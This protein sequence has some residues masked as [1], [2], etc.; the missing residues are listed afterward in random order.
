MQD[1]WTNIQVPNGWDIVPLDKL[2]NVVRGGSPRPMGDPRYFGGTIP[3]V[4]ISDVTRSDGFH[5]YDVE[6]K[7]T[8]DGAKRSRL[9]K[10][11]RLILTNSATVCVPIFLGVD[12]CIHDG[13]VAFDDLPDSIDQKYLYHFFKYIRP[14]ILDKH[15]QGVTQVNLNTQIVGEINLVLAPT[16]EQHRIVAKIEELFSELDKG[17]ENLKT[18]RQ[19]LKVYREAVLNHAFV[20]DATT[21]W[22][23]DNKNKL[24]SAADLITRIKKERSAHHQA[25]ISARNGAPN[26]NGGKPRPLKIFSPLGRQELEELATL[27]DGW[28]WEKLG[29]MTCGVEYGTGAKSSQA[30]E[31]SVLRMGNIQNGKFDWSDLV[32]TSDKEEILKYALTEGDVLFNR[33]NSPEL[34]GKTAIYRGEHPALFA[35]YLIRVNQLPAIADSQYLNLFLNS[36]AAR[37]HGNRVK[38]DGV[39]QSNIN[40]EKLSNYPFPYCSLPEQIEIVKLL[41][42]KLSLVDQMEQEIGFEIRKA[43]SLRQSILKKAFAGRLVAQD[44]N[45]EPARLLLERI[46]AGKGSRENGKTKLRKRN[47]A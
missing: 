24:K 28:I 1:A 2:C 23:K 7:V 26:E 37:K 45:D 10:K 47:A 16:N 11:G 33:T 8:E 19:Q 38:T 40:G 15:K 42:E 39:N 5:L 13:F 35:G 30:G 20:G 36:H 32:Y 41:E 21:R 3:F 6:T 29:W 44:P 4:K 22:R 31:V 17:V 18:A 9:I 34:V 27:P 14:F 43:E 12:A 25:K 46:N